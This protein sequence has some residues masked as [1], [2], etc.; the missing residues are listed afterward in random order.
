MQNSRFFSRSVISR[1][2]KSFFKKYFC[3]L[4]DT[5]VDLYTD[6]EGDYLAYDWMLFL[7]YISYN[8]DRRPGVLFTDKHKDMN[9]EAPEWGKWRN[10]W[11]GTV[12]QFIPPKWHLN[13]LSKVH[14]IMQNYRTE[15]VNKTNPHSSEVL[16]SLMQ[17]WGWNLDK[18]KK[19]SLFWLHFESFFITLIHL[20]DHEIYHIN[21]W[22]L[23]STKLIAF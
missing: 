6:N 9:A 18:M 19:W 16:T 2:E 20:N 10:C 7:E 1:L 23:Y 11:A 4:S 17:D 14:Q 13:L 5:K 12:F 8:R 15:L 21:V 22:P 3:P